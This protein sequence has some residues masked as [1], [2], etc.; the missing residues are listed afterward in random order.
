MEYFLIIIIIVLAYLLFRKKSSNNL[1]E[2]LTR[3]AKTYGK[4]FKQ[5]G[6]TFLDTI[7]ENN[8]SSIKTSS[9]LFVNNMLNPEYVIDPDRA[10]DEKFNQS[11]ESYN[12]KDKL[13]AW[14]PFF[15]G[16][17]DETQAYK[18]M[19]FKMYWVF[20]EINKEEMSKL[21]DFH[22]SNSDTRKKEGNEKL[23]NADKL[24]VYA[25]V[26]KTRKNPIR[27]VAEVDLMFGNNK[28]YVGSIGS[29]NQKGFWE[30]LNLFMNQ[31]LEL[32]DDFINSYNNSE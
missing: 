12:T 32:N 23:L 27:W 17:Y 4:A 15:E 1:K 21:L 8:D 19:Q 29:N 26:Y 24:C 7:K 9:D 6:A 3:D 5:A 10:D 11:I 18:F 2:D 30:K 20:V 14:G 16:K 31:K 13:K 25:N 28:M 22:L